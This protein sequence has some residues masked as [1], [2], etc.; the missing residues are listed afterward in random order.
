LRIV[1]VHATWPYDLAPIDRY[2]A[3]VHS[4]SRWTTLLWSTSLT[5]TVLPFGRLVACRTDLVRTP[6]SVVDD[7]GT[8]RTRSQ[9]RSGAMSAELVREGLTCMS[10][11]DDVRVPVRPSPATSAGGRRVR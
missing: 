5:R 11:G 1:D 6:C 9:G 2:G 8:S 4:G 7:N 3:V 10:I